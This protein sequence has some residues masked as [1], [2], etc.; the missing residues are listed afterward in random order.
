M[1]LT[2]FSMK[3]YS[4]ILYDCLCSNH[5]FV[6]NQSVIFLRF[7]S[8]FARKGKGLMDFYILLKVYFHVLHVYILFS[9]LFCQ[10]LSLSKTQS[11]I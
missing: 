7:Q 3:V 6:A 4:M 10:S 8:V 9:G 5:L 1:C 11:V 2:D